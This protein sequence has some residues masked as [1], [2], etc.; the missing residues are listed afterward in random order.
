MSVKHITYLLEFCLRSIYFTFQDKYYE[1]V[2]RAVMGSPIS[3]TVANLYMEDF[4]MRA[5]NTSPHPPLMWKR[6]VDYTIV[7]IK[8]AH[9]QNFLDNINSVDHYIQFTSKDPRPDGSM[10][11]LD[12]LVT[13]GE[14]VSLGTT[15][16]G[17]LLMQTYICNEIAITP[18]HQN[19]V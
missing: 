4:E 7:V 12:I 5:I 15:V 3:P 17:S 6:F 13:P 10:P 2:E 1:Q 9:K 19:I 14:D 16:T 18:F 11:F 8:A